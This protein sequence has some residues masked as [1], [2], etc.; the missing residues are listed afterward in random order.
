MDKFDAD[1]FYG[2]NKSNYSNYERMNPSETFKTFISFISKEK[3]TGRL[4][5]VGCAFGFLMREL[6]RFF[7]EV[8]GCDISKF[9]IAKAREYNPDADLKVVDIE[10]RL[11]YPDEF[12]D[13]IAALDVLEHT[14]SFEESLRRLITKLRQ[15]GHIII[16]SPLYAWP[17]KLF[18]SLDK[19]KTHIS[20]PRESRLKELIQ[21]LKLV[22]ISEKKFARFPL[23]RRI[24]K[25]PAQIELILKKN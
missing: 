23:L 5:D 19:D 15:G 2:G 18:G 22:I 11:P 13:C 21:E 20:I 12:F 7:S 24:P 9:A 10:E 17:R 16:S 14:K 25:I 3:V 6:K 8:H 4:L 1:Y